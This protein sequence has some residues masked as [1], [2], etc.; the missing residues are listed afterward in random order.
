MELLLRLLTF[1]PQLVEFHLRLM[2]T[3]NPLREL[4]PSGMAPD[5]N[6]LHP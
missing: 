3:T 2:A 5:E 4:G 6:H 1:I